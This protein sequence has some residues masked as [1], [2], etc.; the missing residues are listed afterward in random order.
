MAEIKPQCV[1]CAHYIGQK[2]LLKPR[3]CKAF[4]KGIP[5]DVYLGKV[6]HNEKVKGQVGKYLFLNKNA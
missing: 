6:R 2:N 4:P 1:K 5:E 3:T